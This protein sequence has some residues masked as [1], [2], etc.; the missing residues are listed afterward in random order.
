VIG[1]V[2]AGG[3]GSRLRPLT[4]SVS[5]QLLPIFDK[6]MIYYPISTLMLAGVRK[7][8]IV[9]TPRDQ[10]AFQQL[11]GDGSQLGVEF[12]Y[13]AQPSP[14]GIAAVFSLCSDL[15]EGERVALIL[16]DNV[17]HGNGLGQQ[18]KSDID[19]FTGAQ[20]FGYSV[21]NPSEYGVVEIASDGQIISIQEKPEIPKSNL[22]IPGLYFYDTDVVEMAEVLQPS[23]RGEVEITSLNELYWQQ[24]KLSVRVLP[25]GT[26]WF[27][28]GTFENLFDA[29]SYVRLLQS[30]QGTRIACLEEISWRNGWI[31]TELLENLAEKTQSLN[32]LDY[33]RS[34]VGKNV[35]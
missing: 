17:F 19:K 28:T 29:S 20:I 35:F 14:N 15:I 7:L 13:R 6:P 34:L 10:L 23:S 22:A 21:S 9:T 31:T 2:L 18:L 5:K 30:R 24:G 1:I 33:I 3:T 27:D 12:Q 32:F 25:R 16:G 26:A 11:L 4:S 8:I